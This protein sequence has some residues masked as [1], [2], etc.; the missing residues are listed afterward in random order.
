M[1]RRDWRLYI[2]DILESVARVESYTRGLEMEDLA[3]D[4]L[5]LDAVLHNL[6][7][8]GEAAAQTPA[9]VQQRLPEVP[10]AKMRG[11]RNFIVH[12]YHQVR[13]TVIWE[14]IRHD[15]P[16]I[17]PPLRAALDAKEDDA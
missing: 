13:I 14:T 3:G 6:A 9:D 12:G 16:V 4:D 11:L 15:L 2:D 10:W 5:R 7:I 17:V 1:P 8:I